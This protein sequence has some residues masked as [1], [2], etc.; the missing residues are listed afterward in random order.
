MTIMRTTSKY[1]T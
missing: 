1:V